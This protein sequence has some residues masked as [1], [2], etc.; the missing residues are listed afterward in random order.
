MKRLIIIKNNSGTLSQQDNPETNIINFDEL[1]LWLRTG[2]FLRELFGY[3]EVELRTSLIGAI[4]KPLATA[5]ILRLLGRKHI[6]VVDERGKSY[7]IGFRYFSTGFLKFW[8]ELIPSH[9]LVTAVKAEVTELDKAAVR[10]RIQHPLQPHSVPVYFRTDLI[11]GVH[12]GG[13]VGHIAGVANNLKN[14]FGDLLFLS[15]DSIPT[16][17]QS[18]KQH[19]VVP[20]DEYWDFNEIPSLAFNRKFLNEARMVLSAKKIAFVYQ[21]YSV[22]NYAGLILSRERK[23]PFV[24]EFNGSEVWVAQHWGRPLKYEELSTSIEL[25][26]LRA[27]DVVVVVSQALKEELERRGI[28][29]KKILV[30]PNGVDQNRYSP[31]IDGTKIRQHY[32]LNDKSVVGFIGTFG[33]W[34]GAEKLVNAANELFDRH[35]EFMGRIHFL[36]IGDGE[37]RRQS[38]QSVA[39]KYR[40]SFTF[41]GSVPQDQGAAHMAACDILVAPHVPNPDGSKFF[42]SPTKLFEYMAMGKPIIASNLDQIGEML[43]HKK[44]ALKVEPGNVRQLVEAIA[45]LAH[46]PEMRKTLGAHAR[47]EAVAHHTWERHVENI[48]NKLKDVTK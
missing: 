18:I 22:N 11:F 2:R 34:H 45:S 21:R 35:P 33:P 26:N 25:L 30:N 24:L 6:L 32:S 14:L 13:S 1:K 40:G 7:N 29:S 4:A 41:T 37:R 5:L 31:H 9:F 27:A 8:R 3:E 12:S 17:D 38:E 36:F 23:I 28:G 10:P 16:V 46:D 43:E 19:V 47:A 42:G 39:P 48:V 15:T 20:D 44:T